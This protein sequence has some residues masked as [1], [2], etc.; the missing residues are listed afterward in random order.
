MPAVTG[1][2]L[3]SHLLALQAELRPGDRAK[4]FGPDALFAVRAGAVLVKVQ[5]AQGIFDLAKPAHRA[6]KIA[7]GQVASRGSLNLIHRV[8]YLFDAHLVP[9]AQTLGNLP[10]CVFQLPTIC[11][12]PAS[13]Y[14]SFERA[15]QRQP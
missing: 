3:I 11:R 7:D 4:P 15:I 1:F 9:Q 6:V 2:D 13:W 5:S 8:R 10:V 14:F 12:T